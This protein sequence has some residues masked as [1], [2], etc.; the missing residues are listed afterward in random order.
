MIRN[1]KNLKPEHKQT[2]QV[3]SWV[4][5]RKLS[6]WSISL[7]WR[8]IPL[9]WHK[10]GANL[11]KLTINSPMNRKTASCIDHQGRIL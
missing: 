4:S 7:N 6:T 11:T 5:T 10:N 3:Q 2:L 1:G 9:K 8:N